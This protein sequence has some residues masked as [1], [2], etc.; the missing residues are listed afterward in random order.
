MPQL[1][2]KTIAIVGGLALLFALG[3]LLLLYARFGTVPGVGLEE[4]ITSSPIEFVGATSTAWYI[5][6]G[7]TLHPVAAPA[8]AD[9]FRSADPDMIA[10][11][12][13]VPP[14]KT[15]DADDASRAASAGYSAIAVADT[16]VAGASGK[17]VLTPGRPLGFLAGDSILALTSFGLSAVSLE[18][19]I[20]QLIPT[21]ASSTS[22]IE[23]ISL[24]AANSDLTLVAVENRTAL[25]VDLYRFDVKT[26]IATHLAF[27]AL[28]ETVPATPRGFARILKKG[29]GYAFAPV[30]QAGQFVGTTSGGQPISDELRAGINAAIAKE[31][32]RM[33]SNPHPTAIALA[34]NSLIV[35]SSTG[36]FYAYQIS[37]DGLGKLAKLTVTAAP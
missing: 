36:A 17:H 32:D 26:R 19:V 25:G 34:G 24:G 23:A 3:V 31:K 28:P 15:R 27:A 5:R 8:G 11:R 29:G 22:S 7:D 30:D 10:Y 6:T 1:H 14:V 16:D 33:L 4:T 13:F 37:D 21:S 20:D 35:R 18:G 12:E 2:H 9:T